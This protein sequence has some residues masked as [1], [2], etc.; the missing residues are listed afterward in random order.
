MIELNQNK[1]KLNNL[2]IVSSKFQ[3]LNAI[4]A[5]KI[6][7]ENEK[8]YVIV[9]VLNKI[10]F[11]QIIELKK[12]NNINILFK[13]KFRT[14]FQY[15]DLIFKIIKLRIN[16]NI[17]NLV[18]GHLN[19]NM[20][21][22]CI[23]L[24]NFNKLKFVDDGEILEFLDKKPL[25]NKRHLPLEYYSIFRLKSNN[26]YH[27]YENNYHSLKLNHKKDLTNRVLFIGSPLVEF[28]TIPKK[29][30]L[31]IMEKVLEKEGQFDYFLHPRELTDKFNNINN[32]KYFTYKSGIEQYIIDCDKLPI[33]L[34]SFYSTAITSLRHILNVNKI[35]LKFIDLRK[36]FKSESIRDVEY[37]YLS[38]NFIEYELD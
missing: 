10:H 19:N 25:I 9:L 17:D 23:K 32:I 16:Y 36:Y 38:E 5:T 8:L 35:N 29:L 7:S 34:I 26:Y 24:L 3:L 20:M 33:K 31:Q 13:V 2:A 14:F 12:H 22:L 4:E 18:I 21:L 27:F 37:D 6:F 28:D 1:I 15:F 11:K 30:F